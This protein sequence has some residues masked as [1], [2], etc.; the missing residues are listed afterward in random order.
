VGREARVVV[1]PEGVP[2]QLKDLR[3]QGEKVWVDILMGLEDETGGD[4]DATYT[5]II[6]RWP[7]VFGV[8]SRMYAR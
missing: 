5:E 7:R 2:V 6:G 4:V 1:V 8:T 3:Q